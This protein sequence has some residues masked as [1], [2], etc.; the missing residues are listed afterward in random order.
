MSTHA[1]AAPRITTLTLRAVLSTRDGV[2]VWLPSGDVEA[3]PAGLTKAQ[4]MDPALVVVLTHGEAVS[5]LAAADGD[6]RAAAEAATAVLRW[7]HT[8]G[9]LSADDDAAVTL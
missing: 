6:H 8:L 3:A 1:T 9:F 4:G 7:Q 5:L 2:A